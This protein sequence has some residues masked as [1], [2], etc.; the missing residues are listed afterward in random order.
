MFPNC[1]TATNWKLPFPLMHK[2]YTTRLVAKQFFVVLP[3]TIIDLSYNMRGELYPDV[4]VEM[5]LA[6]ISHQV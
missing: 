1:Y 6:V 5:T 3:M 2:I 4:F